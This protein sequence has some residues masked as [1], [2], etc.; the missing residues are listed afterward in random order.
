[1]ISP[2]FSSQTTVL[3][4]AQI[5][6]PITYGKVTH[7]MDVV[8]MQLDV[9]KLERGIYR[10]NITCKQQAGLLVKLSQA[11]ELFV[12]EI[13]HTNIIVITSTRVTCTFVVKVNLHVLLSFALKMN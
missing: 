10:L 6:V 8:Q 2:E 5:S 3:K 13:V 11:I 7:C 1:M 12:L 4:P 9:S